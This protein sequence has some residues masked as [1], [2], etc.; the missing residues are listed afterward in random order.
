MLAAPAVGRDDLGQ[1]RHP[2]H[3]ASDR[4]DVVG[5]AGAG[6]DVRG[7]VA[8]RHGV[9]QHVR[10]EAL[11]VDDALGRVPLG[12][13]LGQSEA[14]RLGAGLL[15][16]V[17]LLLALPGDPV[18]DVVALDLVDGQVVDALEPGAR[19]HPPVVL[20]RAR[21]GVGSDGLEVRLEHLGQQRRPVVGVSADSGLDRGQ[22]HLDALGLEEVPH[23][24][25]RLGRVHGVR[26]AQLA[27]VPVA[28]AVGLLTGLG[29]ARLDAR[30]VVL[31]PPGYG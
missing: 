1:M 13:G 3:E 21:G 24:H 28:D 15:G 7:H 9:V 17:R 27:L 12:L 20:D 18:G 8:L 4:L 14:P 23:V 6:R 25:G 30:H 10:Q 29:G 16:P 11:G 2:V 5:H 22:G 26:P 19:G 31:R